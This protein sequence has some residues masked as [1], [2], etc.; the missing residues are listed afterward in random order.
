MLCAECCELCAVCCKLRGEG[1]NAHNER[2]H[3]Q[4]ERDIR[5]GRY[6]NE[7]ILTFEIGTF[8]TVQMGTVACVRAFYF[9][10][11]SITSFL[12]ALSPATSS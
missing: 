4:A 8:I 7:I 1:G 3:T 11:P 2:E 6:R 9:R 10:V 12:K 5:T